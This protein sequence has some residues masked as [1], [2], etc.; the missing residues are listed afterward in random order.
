MKNERICITPDAPDGYKVFGTLK[1]VFGVKVVEVHSR[2]YHS[3]DLRLQVRQL[4]D[5][6]CNTP[7]RGRWIIEDEQDRSV[8]DPIPTKREAFE[9]LVEWQKYNAERDAAREAERAARRR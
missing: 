1:T 7:S 8:S 5:E 3:P 2:F 9:A 4:A 6:H